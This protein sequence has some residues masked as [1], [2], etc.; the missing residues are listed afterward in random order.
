[1]SVRVGNMTLALGAVRRVGTPLITVRA[2]QSLVSTQGVNIST[3][4][5]QGENVKSEHS[6]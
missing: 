6:T 1:M 3:E 4:N 2:S 5:T